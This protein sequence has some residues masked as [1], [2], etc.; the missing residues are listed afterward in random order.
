M[1]DAEARLW[2]YLRN[3]NVNRR[4]FRGQ[5]PYGSYTLDFYCEYAKVV[6]EVDG[7]QH[8]EEPQAAKDAE[9]T[10]FLNARGIRVLRFN[11]REVLLETEAVVEV[12]LRELELP[13]P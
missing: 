1:T 4:K 3:R 2:Y 9:R 6:V 13:S 7:S 10:A 11:N 8:F 12:I 5:H